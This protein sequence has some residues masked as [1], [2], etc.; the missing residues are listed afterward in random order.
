MFG[1]VPNCT[2][3]VPFYNADILDLGIL[4][5]LVGAAV[6]VGQIAVITF[7]IVFQDSVPAAGLD[8]LESATQLGVAGIDGTRMVVITSSRA[9]SFFAFSVHATLAFQAG[10]ADFTA[11]ILTTLKVFTRVHANALVVNALLGFSTHSA[12]RITSIVAAVLV[13][14]VRKAQASTII[15]ADFV[16]L[17]SPALTILYRTTNPAFTEFFTAWGRYFTFSL[18]VANPDGTF[19]AVTT[20]RL[21]TFQTVTNLNTRVI[22][23]TN[24]CFATGLTGFTLAAVTLLVNTT[25]T[26]YAELVAIL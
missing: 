11:G 22:N 25:G 24:T 21:A 23:D 8:P 17:T 5:T 16:V 14:A 6:I 3:L 10:S 19:P 4:D 15:Q 18:F 7:F 13:F 9:I 1:I 2:I 26:G 20:I 12:I